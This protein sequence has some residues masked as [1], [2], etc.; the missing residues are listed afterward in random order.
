MSGR[1]VEAS[2]TWTC[3]YP[4][5][6]A[7]SRWETDKPRSETRT[8]ISAAHPNR[9]QR[10]CRVTTANR[11][12]I[13]KPARRMLSAISFGVFCRD[14]PST[15]RIMRSRNV[16]P[17]FEV[18]RTRSRPRA[19]VCRRLRR[20]GHPQIRELQGGF[21]GDSGFVYRPH[22][23][24]NL[25]VAGNQFSGRDQHL[26]SRAK[27]RTR[28]HL[29]RPVRPQ[30]MRCCFRTRLSQCFRLSFGRGLPPWLRRNLQRQR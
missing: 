18:M 16:S 1:A 13:V 17:G 20:N 10:G 15:S 30:T 12:I 4:T 22:S 21:A 25:A 3:F 11:K 19:R 2:G 5:R 9:L 8:K 29:D 23:F 6:P 14:A 27:L 26:I 7:Q 24:D 28:Y